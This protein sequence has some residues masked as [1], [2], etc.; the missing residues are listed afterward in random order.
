[1]VNPDEVPLVGKDGTM[2]TFDKTSSWEQVV[3]GVLQKYPDKLQD[4][5]KNKM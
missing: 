1:M 2:R 4:P 5:D 3:R